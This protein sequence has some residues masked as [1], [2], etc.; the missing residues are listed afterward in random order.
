MNPFD[1]VKTIQNSKENIMPDEA[2]EKEYIPFIVNKALSYHFDCVLFASEMNQ[3]P[4]LDKKMQYS[5]LMSTIRS[6][7]RP[8]NKWIKREL[9]E[10]L[11]TIQKS[12]HVSKRK[13]QEML[14]LLTSEQVSD[15]KE[16]LQ[17]GGIKKSK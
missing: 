13:A 2:A 14:P 12:F 10:D 8:F 16:K 9:S 3:R 7:K 4:L 17:T 6:K 15:L 5:Y 11:D 1:F